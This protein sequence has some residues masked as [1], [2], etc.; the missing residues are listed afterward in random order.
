MTCQQ[1]TNHDWISKLDKQCAEHNARVRT[2]FSRHPQWPNE[3][4]A[5][6]LCRVLGVRMRQCFPASQIEMFPDYDQGGI[7]AYQR[8]QVAT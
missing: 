2:L 8:R 6:Y 1:Q 7:Y 4:N 5:Q 3:S